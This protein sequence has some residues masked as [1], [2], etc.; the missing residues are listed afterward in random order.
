MLRIKKYNDG[1]RVYGYYNGD[2]HILITNNNFQIKTVTNYSNNTDEQMN[3]GTLV[4]DIY[5]YFNVENYTDLLGKV[6]NLQQITI[7]SKVNFDEIR[8]DLKSE[9]EM[10]K[11][12]VN[13]HA[14]GEQIKTKI[15][16]KLKSE[17]SEIEIYVQNRKSNKG[18]I[19]ISVDV[20]A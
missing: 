19:T 7:Q 6:V 18:Y 16:N 20:Y 10:A 4:A 8:K 15:L 5:D 11:V 17:F 14:E 2:D 12:V 3:V 1:V 13:N 9:N